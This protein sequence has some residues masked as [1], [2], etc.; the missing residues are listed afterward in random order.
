MEPTTITFEEFTQR[1]IEKFPE[2]FQYHKTPIQVYT[3]EGLFSKNIQT[4]TPLLKANFNFIVF[5]LEGE[6]QQL[7]GSE[8]KAVSSNQ[9]L[10]I[11]QNEVSSLL[12]KS[13]NI[14]GYYIIFDDKV[15][16]ELEDHYYLSKLFSSNPIINIS[17]KDAYFLCGIC[18]LIINELDSADYSSQIVSHLFQSL[19]IKLLKSSEMRKNLSRQ[20]DIAISFRKLVYQNFDEQL[21]VQYYAEQ[22]HISTNYLNRCT[23]NIWSKSAKQFIQEISI[24]QSQQYL[25]SSKFSISEVAYLLGYN[26]PSY[27]G[28]L[29]KKIIGK[30]PQAFRKEIMHD[31]SD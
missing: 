29:F 21:T 16:Q 20:F 4:P 9:A 27:F 26:D 25:Q 10:L 11:T 30:T 12:T 6:F 2:K 19:L 7:V 31:S 22:L 15:L 17:L 5:V 8:I 3:L 28:R 14:K 23:Q 18:S 1:F 13:S 24:I